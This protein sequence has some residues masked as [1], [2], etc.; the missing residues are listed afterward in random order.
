M[1]YQTAAWRLFADSIS[2]KNAE[3]QYLDLVPKQL[4]KISHTS[5][6]QKPHINMI[7]KNFKQI[8]PK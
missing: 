3:A 4:N 2:S 5:T 1:G 7:L 8:D 6:I